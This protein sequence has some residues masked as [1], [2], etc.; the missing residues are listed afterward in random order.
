MNQDVTIDLQS[1]R[2]TLVEAL[3]HVK[4]YKISSGRKF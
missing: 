4:K 3:K 2:G 1:F